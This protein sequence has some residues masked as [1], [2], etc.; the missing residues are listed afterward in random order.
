ML[1]RLQLQ[2]HH[3]LVRDKHGL[4]TTCLLVEGSSYSN[5]CKYRIAPQKLAPFLYAL[6]LPNIN[7]FSKL[8]D[9]QNQENVRNN[10]IT[11]DP[12]TPQV[13]RYITL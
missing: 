8:Y 9:C 2:A 10:T 7:R 1:N 11:K 13:C 4:A 5:R 12:T 6:I 3:V